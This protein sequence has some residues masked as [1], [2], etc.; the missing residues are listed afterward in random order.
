MGAG[1]SGSSYQIANGYVKYNYTPLALISRYYYSD[2]SGTYYC[3]PIYTPLAPGAGEMGGA[4]ASNIAW[5]TAMNGG[6]LTQNIPAYGVTV[7]F[8]NTC[9]GGVTGYGTI[10][11]DYSRLFQ[12]FAKIMDYG[13]SGPPADCKAANYGIDVS[14][15][16][17]QAAAYYATNMAFQR[18][19]GQSQSTHDNGGYSSAGNRG[20][21]V[22][23]YE[24]FLEE[25][26]MAILCK[27]ADTFPDIQGSIG[28]PSYAGINT[29]S[30][31]ITVNVPAGQNASYYSNTT[32]FQWTDLSTLARQ[33]DAA[34]ASYLSSFHGA[35]SVTSNLLVNADSIKGGEHISFSI[36]G[37]VGSIQSYAQ[38]YYGQGSGGK[39]CY[40]VGDNSV[41]QNQTVTQDQ[42]VVNVSTNLPLFDVQTTNITCN[43]S[44]NAGDIGQVKVAYYNNSALPAENVPVSLSCSSPLG[45]P[46]TIT[47]PNQ[48]ISELQ[49]GTSTTVTYNVTA[50]VLS[51]NATATFTAKIG[52][53]DYPAPN[54]NKPLPNARFNETNYTNNTLSNTTTVYSVPDFSCTFPVSDYIAGQDAVFAVTVNNG[55]IIG[56]P[57]V[58]VRLTVGSTSYDTTIPVPVGQNLAVFRVTMP[59]VTGNVNVTAVVDPNNIIPELNESNNTTTHQAPVTQLHTPEQIDALNPDM[60]QAYLTNNKQLPT[61]PN[62][63]DSTTHTWQEYRYENGNYVLHTYTATLSVTF[64]VKPDRRVSD[65]TVI[66]SGFGIEQAAGAT[67]ATNY[68]HPE[69]LVGIQDVWLTYPETYYGVDSHYYTGYYETM[70]SGSTGALTSAWEY[71]NNPNSIKNMPLH[72]IPLWY[73]DGQ[74]TMLCTFFGAWSPDGKMYADMPGSVT[75]DGSMYDR[76]TAVGY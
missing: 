12:A 18:I 42:N 32:R 49:A 64:T 6:S 73:P 26:A 52:N 7:A 66:Q 41:I 59:N 22:L 72:Y 24:Y 3:F 28:A 44:Y 15:A 56:N 55:G 10:Q 53:P 29:V 45:T 60:E 69:K 68:D 67:L 34:V 27:Q 62:N 2:A 31:P 36:Q 39:Y 48:M 30:I 35:S 61:A 37:K 71:P 70:A 74:Y 76:I 58:P 5:Q 16:A 21:N 20:M 13:V 9:D 75:V 33:N 65:N 19:S 11:A 17:G 43:A 54:Q 8:R 4:T 63:A 38:I 57:N 46:F 40:M 14:T 23:N 51:G 47:N 1:P 25:Q 50:N